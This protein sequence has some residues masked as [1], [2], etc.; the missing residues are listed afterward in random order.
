[1]KLSRLFFTRL[2]LVWIFVVAHPHTPVILRCVCT[3]TKVRANGLVSS[4]VPCEGNIAV[5]SSF[6]CITA[7]SWTRP[8]LWLAKIAQQQARTTISISERQ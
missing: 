7:R 2:L 1:M 6:L 5:P 3:Q 8:L 4:I